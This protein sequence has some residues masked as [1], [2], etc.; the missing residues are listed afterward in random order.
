MAAHHTKTFALIIRAH[1]IIDRN[2]NII[3]KIGALVIGIAF[4]RAI[5]LR[6]R[7][8]FLQLARGNIISWYRINRFTLC[9]VNSTQIAVSV[10]LENDDHKT[11]HAGLVARAIFDAYLRGIYRAEGEFINTVPTNNVVPGK[12]Q[13]AISDPE[14]DGAYESDTY[15]DS[16]YLQDDV[17]VPVEDSVRPNE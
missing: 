3:L 12:L 2:L 17:K 11:G 7:N 4:I 15:D 13:K 6:V 5:S 10:I 16:A 8:S 9:T 14:A 1:R